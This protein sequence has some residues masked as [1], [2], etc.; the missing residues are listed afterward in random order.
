MA[1]RNRM[2]H[3]GMTTRGYLN[4]NGEVKVVKR[5]G[6]DKLLHAAQS[7]FFPAAERFAVTRAD[8]PA[9][10]TAAVPDVI[11]ER[12]RRRAALDELRM[13]ASER[14][15]FLVMLSRDVE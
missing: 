10:I 14:V 5:T 9:P 4:S 8:G 11:Q 7:Y 15:H 13:V 12:R 2:R 3:L 6:L 1:V